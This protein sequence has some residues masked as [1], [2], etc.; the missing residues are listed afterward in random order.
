MPK[1]VCEYSNIDHVNIDA[2]I[3]FGGTR[4]GFSTKTDVFS[5]PLPYP[6]SCQNDPNFQ[7]SN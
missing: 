2:Y 5:P 1:M 3:K 7:I 4:I 6:L